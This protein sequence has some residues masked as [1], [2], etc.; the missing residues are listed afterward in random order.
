MR[1]IHHLLAVAALLT[2]VDAHSQSWVDLTP[3]AGSAPAGRRNASAIHDP[4]DNRMV[5]FGGFSSG[6]HNDIWAF[7]LDTNTWAN[8][9]PVSG[10]APAPRLTP[11]GVYD[12]DGHRMI[13]W[14]G[15]GAGAFFNDVWA[16]DFDT[17]A[18]SQF[19]PVTGGP[20]QI[21]YGVGHTWDPLA[22]ELV[23]FAGFTNLG[24]FD[25]VWRFDAAVAT[26]TNVSPGVGP[27]A[28]CLHA[29]CYDAQRHR[30]IMYAG[31]NNDGPLEDIWALDLDTNTWTDL[32]PA[33]RPAGRY[34]SPIIYDP[35]NHRVTMFG[36]QGFFGLSNEA[37]VFDLWTRL[38]TQLSPSG[39]PPTPR[40]GSAAIYDDANDRMIIFGGIDT[41]VRNHV[42]SLEG[43]SDTSTPVGDAPPALVLQPNFPNPFNPSTTIEYA[44]P[45][46]GRVS[47]R[48]FAVNGALVRTLV[49]G[50]EGAGSR[51]VMWD[52]R[53]EDGLR[54]ASGVYVL[55]I[56][57][58]GSSQS[59]KMVLLK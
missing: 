32:T 26:W 53:D 33:V 58:A 40:A 47:L 31:Q 46:R 12:P 35:A 24:R 54:V 23:T 57:A 18:W 10:P 7:D 16:F 20:P 38:W 5:I 21:R 1:S 4:V 28:R 51:R 52:G 17:N 59:R 11:A 36:G 49:D 13:T 22:K 56:E 43:L 55:R 44:I 8:L 34:F 48:V 30:M 14:S 45:A 50:V 15:Q 41:A 9:T 42:W 39:T 29:A 3:A 25:D 19:T 27:L 6:Y 37:W 2:A